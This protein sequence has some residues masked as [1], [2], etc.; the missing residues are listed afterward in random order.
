MKPRIWL[1]CFLST[2]TLLVLLLLLLPGPS[3]SAQDDSALLDQVDTLVGQPVERTNDDVQDHTVMEDFYVYLPL[4]KRDLDTSVMI[5]ISA[6]EFQM[7]CDN[8]NPSEPCNN[9]EQPLHTVYLD[10]YTIDKYEVTN[11][12]YAQCVA[13]G[14]CDPPAY[15]SSSTRDPYYGNLTYDNYPIIYVT[16]YSA[17]DYC[18]W[19]GKRLPT[20]AEWEKAARGSSDTRMFPWGNEIADCSRLNYDNCVGDTSQVGSYPTGAS[21]YGVMDMGGNVWEWTNDWYQ[22]D[23]Y[24][25]SPYSNPPGPSSGSYKVMRGGSFDHYLERIRV[26]KR[27]YSISPSPR[28]NNIGFRCVGSATSP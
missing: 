23:Y 9:N 11:A 15:N 17:T 20:E 21:F 16:W 7:G 1:Y 6:G 27:Y 14:A 2:V 5:L 26:A 12:Q 8:T 25:I 3:L 10:A 19:A 13:A 22:S 24:S 18:T 28:G 4:I